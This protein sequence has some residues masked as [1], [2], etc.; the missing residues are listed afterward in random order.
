MSPVTLGFFLKGKVI[1]AT[2]RKRIGKTQDFTLYIGR[3]TL[4][5]SF[6][7]RQFELQYIKLYDVATHCITIL[8]SDWPSWPPYIS[9]YT[10]SSKNKMADSSAQ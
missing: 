1:C 6:Q 3:K 10:V 7:Q 2:F 5:V 8:Q 4:N 9:S